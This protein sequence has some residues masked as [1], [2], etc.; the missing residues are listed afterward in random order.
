MPP[1][2]MRAMMWREGGGGGLM[3]APPSAPAPAPTRDTSPLPLQC[4]GWFHLGCLGV[5]H[6][7]DVPPRPWFHC[8]DCK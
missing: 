1:L 7:E 4:A 3:R 6:I 2:D 5:E 8:K